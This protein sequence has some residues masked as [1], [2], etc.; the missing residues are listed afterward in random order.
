MIANLPLDEYLASGH[1]GCAGCGQ[2]LAARIAL[3]AGG[4][5]TIVVN[6]TGCLE[7]FS[8]PYPL[9]AWRI[10]WIH[11]AFENAAA[12][13]SGVDRA[14]KKLKKRDKINLLV[15]AGDGGTFDIGFQALSGATERGHN[16]CYVCFDNGAYMNTGIQRSGATPKYASTTTSP[17]GKKVHGKTEFE[18]PLPLIMATHGA[19]VATANIAFPQDFF[20]KVQKGLEKEGPAYVQVYAPCPTGWKHP[21]NVT[22]EIGKLA[23]NSHVT[24]LYE[25]EDGMLKFTM[26]PSKIVPVLDYLKTQGR[27][28]HLNPKEVEDVQHFVDSEWEKLKDFE[29]KR[30]RLY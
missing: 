30:V 16:F 6:A 1:S 28:K 5:N 27:F 20:K 19:Y 23:F 26:E 14:L 15:F 17:A 22:I 7:V 11:G 13:A 18:K 24:P 4:K 2:A 9:T 21:S 8:T 29:D 25:I 10:P 12:I 3:K